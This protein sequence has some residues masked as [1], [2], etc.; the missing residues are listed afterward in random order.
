MGWKAALVSGL[1]L[2]FLVSAV[3]AGI[4]LLAPSNNAA[5]SFIQPQPGSIAWDGNEPIKVLFIGLDASRT[6]A[7]AMAVASYDPADS[8][9]RILSLPPSL[10][11]TIPGFGQDRIVDSYADGGPRLALLTAQSVTRT[12]IPYYVVLD[13]ETFQR[14]VDSYGG[15][16]I[17]SSPG[18]HVWDG[19]TALMYM[20]G[21]AAGR[22]GE[23]ERMNRDAA[24]AGAVLRAAVQPANQLQI[25]SLISDLGRDIRTNFPYSRVP[26]LLRRLAHARVSHDSLDESNGSAAEYRSSSGPVLVPDWQR[27]STMVRQIFPVEGL[28]SG[29][30]EVL[31]G[32]GVVGQAAALASWLRTF[33]FHVSDFGSASKFNVARTVVVI[34]SGAAPTDRPLAR[35][36][37]AVLQAPVVTRRVRASRASVVVIIGSDY[38]DVTQQ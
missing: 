32:S 28:R 27:I 25:V 2:I 15:L 13:P 29:R 16:S 35:S 26:A 5:A 38:Q 34:N 30:V 7:T 6:N 10:W 1:A 36:L 9:V 37:S 12:V 14:L 21:A 19:H 31:N 33:G 4:F 8:R 3:A 17:Q 24:I 11:I 18:T 23:A 20:A 22:N